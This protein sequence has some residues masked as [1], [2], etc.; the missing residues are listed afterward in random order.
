M[1]YKD[2]LVS[3]ADWDEHVLGWYLR[4]LCHQ[5]DKQGGLPN[6]VESLAVLA[7]VKFSK[8]NLFVECWGRTLKAKFEANAEGLLV[9]KKQQVNL[10]GRRTYKENQSKRGLVGH[11]IKKAKAVGTLSKEQ[12]QQLS[13]QLFE[14]LSIENSKE[15]N[16]GCYKRTLQAYIGNADGNAIV[17]VN[18]NTGKGGAGERDEHPFD[19]D[20][21]LEKIL[22]DKNYLREMESAGVPPSKLE[23]WMAAFNRF[24]VFKGATHSTEG[25]WR[26][27][28]PAWLQHQNLNTEPENYK[29]ANYGKNERNSSVIKLV[30]SERPYGEAL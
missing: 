9:N 17:N 5:A 29:P 20:L 16:E 3:C 28:F 22:L 1:Y 14:V 30:T 2:I 21:L 11:Y 18:T 10:E 13:A 8:F 12:L 7:G 27:G 26:L 24:L 15:E 6:D 4:L 25:G 19:N 23:G